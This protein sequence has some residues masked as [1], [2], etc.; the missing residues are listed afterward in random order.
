MAGGAWI[1][2]R[3][4]EGR[5]FYSALLEGSCR[6]LVAG[7]APVT[8]EAGDFVLV[9]AARDFAISSLQPPEDG[10]ARQPVEVQPGV[11]RLGN[12]DDPPN[13]RMLV[14]H[15]RFGSNDAGLLV[16]LL[17][18]LVHVR[19]R[20]RLFTLVHLVSEE[21]RGDQ[22]GRDVV[23]ARLLEVLLIEALCS[24]AGPAAPPGLLR[25]LAD[26]RLA[27][28]LRRMHDDPTRV[29]TVAELA[30]GSSALAVDL[31]RAVQARAGRGT[32]GVPAG[33]AHGA[34]EGPASPGQF[35]HRPGRRTR[36]LQLGQH[37]QRR[38]RPPCRDAADLLCARA[39]DR[40]NRRTIP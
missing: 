27:V 16:S 9:P 32:H 11:F 24:T 33:L 34:G 4:D 30:G 1:V 12:R 6:L 3:S 2:R 15:C 19:G 26:D 37:L 31:L 29:W 35:R 40:G 7:Q 39:A 14:G 13:V 10:A 36:G 25:G 38:L 22:P 17:P 18:Q 20:A 8:L 5:P 21:S 28:A 23:L